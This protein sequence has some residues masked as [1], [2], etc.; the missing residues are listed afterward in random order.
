MT[1]SEFQIRLFAYKRMEGIEFQK[2]RESMWITYVAPHLDPKKMAKTKTS[3]LPLPTDKNTRNGVS[4]K[5][6]ANFIKEFQKW[7]KNSQS[8]LEQISPT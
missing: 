1:W 6:K 7:Q 4:E 3:F 2:M 5:Q 8:K